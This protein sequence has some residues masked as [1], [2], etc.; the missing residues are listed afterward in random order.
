MGYG[1]CDGAVDADPRKL[2]MLFVIKCEQVKNHPDVGGIVGQYKHLFLPVLI[3]MFLEAS[4]LNTLKMQD[5]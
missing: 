1:C 4:L 3:Q 2:S 5:L